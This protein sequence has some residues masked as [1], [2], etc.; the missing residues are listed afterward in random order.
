MARERRSPEEIVAKLRQVEA[1]RLR[2]KTCAEAVRSIGV[3]EVTYRRWRAEFGGLIR[4]LGPNHPSVSPITCSLRTRPT[5]ISA[6]PIS[7]TS[8]P[9]AAPRVSRHPRTQCAGHVTPTRSGVIF[10]AVLAWPARW[11]LSLR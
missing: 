7:T 6:K 2:G 9:A 1:L 5:A 10:V 8:R 3:S 11:Y 4:T